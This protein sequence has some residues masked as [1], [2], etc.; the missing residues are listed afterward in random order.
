MKSKNI[1]Y[2][3]CTVLLIICLTSCNDEFL[4]PK[5]PGNILDTD[6]YKN[7]TEAFSG[8]T[9]VYDILRKQSGGFEN[10]VTMMNAGSDDHIA[11]GTGDQNGLAIQTF[12]TFKITSTTIAGSFWNDMYQGIYRANTMLQKIPNVPMPES[13]KLRFIA[14]VKTLRAFYYFDL[15]R[16]FKNIPLITTPLQTA[17]ILKVNQANPTDV[18]AQI[19]KDLLEAIPNLP[20]TIIDK[21]NENGRLTQGAAKAILGKAYLFQGKNSQ[22]AVQLADVNGTPNVSN[23]YGYKLLPNFK[24]LWIFANKFTT[25]SI[26]EVN[27]TN[28]SNSDFNN[29]GSG[30]DEG[31][32]I[33]VMTGV[34]D[35]QL[36]PG[37]SATNYAGGWGFNT[38]TQNLY[39]FIKFDP[40]FSETVADLKPLRAANL[41][42]FTDSFRDQTGFYL[43]KFMPKKSDVTGG[44]GSPLTNFQQNYMVIRLADTYLME[45]EALGGTGARAQLLLDVVRARVGLPS[46]PVSIAAIWD[47]RRLELA[48]EGHRFFDLVRT[49]RAAAALTSRGFI[50]GKNEILPIPF[51][52]TQNTLIVQN[53]L[54]D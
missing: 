47:E 17:D 19:E 7:E 27:H 11:G 36:L 42:R 22:A 48:G 9:S 23:I 52:E 1:L 44:A 35:Y 45:A 37:S 5:A 40:R 28:K 13:K 8:L 53:P 51:A 21:A 6:F 3:L 46:R 26:L 20:I 32:I 14:E 33:N 12:A 18:Y 31:N 29:W 49:G 38:F 41:I 30:S 39:D 43:K 10:M 54:Y 34:I 25:E 4:E 2:K 50:A 16:M 24:D 15:V